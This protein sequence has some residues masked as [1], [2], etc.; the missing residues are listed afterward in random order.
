MQDTISSLTN[1]AIRFRD[2]RGWKQ[3]HNAKDMALSLVLESSEVLELMQW[4]NGDELVSHLRQKK[5]QLSDELS[6]VL[7]WVLQLA[8]DQEIDLA[9]AFHEKLKKNAIKY[10]VEK[11]RGRAAKYTEL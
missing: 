3:F 2:E 5:E 8:H 7:C 4:K 11:A 10:P 6:D 1:L 9:Q